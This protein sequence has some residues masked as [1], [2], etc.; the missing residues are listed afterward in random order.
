MPISY[1][2]PAQPGPREIEVRHLLKWLDQIAV[3]EDFGATVQFHPYRASLLAM[4]VRGSNIIETA[5][6]QDLDAPKLID[7]ADDN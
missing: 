7:P 6:R 4:A 2:N 3:R 1:A 5:Q